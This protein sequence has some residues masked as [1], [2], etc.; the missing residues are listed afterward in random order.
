MCKKCISAVNHFLLNNKKNKT[1]YKMG[2][3]FQFV[4]KEKRMHYPYQSI[5]IRELWTELNSGNQ[6]CFL[7]KQSIPHAYVSIEKCTKCNHL[8]GH[9]RCVSLWRMNHFNCPL[10]LM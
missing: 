7:C 1:K 9:S 10:C 8:V 6:T 5:P 3:C 2:N 4:I